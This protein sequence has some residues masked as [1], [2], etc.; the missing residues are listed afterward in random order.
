MDYFTELLESFDKIKKRTYKLTYICEA[1][2][3]EQ[4]EPADPKTLELAIQKVRAAMGAAPEAEGPAN[5]MPVE[6]LEDPPKPSQVKA[7]KKTDSKGIQKTYLF[8]KGANESSPGAKIASDPNGDREDRIR[9]AAEVIAQGETLDKQGQDIE[10]AE[11]AEADAEAAR[12]AAEKE[13][14]TT[15]KGTAEADGRSECVT[16]VVAMEGFKKTLENAF[17]NGVLPSSAKPIRNALDFMHRLLTGEVRVVVDEKTGKT[18]R[19]QLDA[20]I[21]GECAESLESFVSIFEQEPNDENELCSKAKDRVGFY[22]GDL[23]AFSKDKTQAMVVTKKKYL[24][25]AMSK[26]FEMYK[27]TCPQHDREAGDFDQLANDNVA[28]NTK[29]AVKG[30]FFESIIESTWHAFKGDYKKAVDVLNKDIKNNR[31]V[32]EAIQSERDPDAG[33]TLEQAYE[34]NVQ[35]ETIKAM[36]NKSDLKKLIMQEQALIHKTIKHMGGDSFK[37]SSKAST[38]MGREDFYI[39]FNDGSEAEEKASSLGITIKGKDVGFGLKRSEEGKKMKCGEL[40]Q[41]RLMGLCMGDLMDQKIEPGAHERIL[42]TVFDGDMDRREKAREVMTKVEDKVETATKFLKEPQTYIDSE[43]KIKSTTP[44]TVYSTIAERAMEMGYGDLKTSPFKDL[45]F[46]TDKE[47]KMTKLDLDGDSPE[48]EQRRQFLSEHMGRIV[49]WNEYKKMSKDTAA[50]DAMKMQAFSTGGNVRDFVQLVGD[51]KGRMRGVLQNQVFEEVF[52]DP[53]V[54]FEFKENGVNIKTDKGS[55]NLGQ[56]RTKSGQG[57]TERADTRTQV[58]FDDKTMDNF[59]TKIDL[60]P[61]VKEKT[62]EHI[63][64]KFLVGQMKLLESLMSQTK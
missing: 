61:K 32:L 1:E 55:I 26:A 4:P 8:Y 31:V 54:K 24:P 64:Q 14:R 18:T 43:G 15:I 56:E 9:A 37:R 29:N 6:N 51:D 17:Q 59:S 35:S 57:P 27:K 46:N 21:I 38:T 36:S 52:R 23:V 40:G 12:I 50:Q 33:S 47:G 10:S 58:T 22:K 41:V 13:L 11:K 25:I 42:E 44:A 2:A 28:T 30:T 20:V 63:L 45:L 62:E 34:E 7:F 16:A 60:S 19:G 39:G 3:K 48:A 5:G 49:R 53:N